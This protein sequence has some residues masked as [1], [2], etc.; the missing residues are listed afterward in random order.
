MSATAKRILLVEDNDVLQR[1]LRRAL[2]GRGHVVVVTANAAEARA[3]SGSYDVGV[4]D[5]ELPDGDSV[6]LA[7]DLLAHGTVTEVVFFTATRD[8]ALIAR[9]EL[10]GTV[11]GKNVDDLLAE[12]G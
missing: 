8:P 12:L 5:G 2:S 9:A 7:R 1:T 10:V 3:D 4:I 6:D 11:I